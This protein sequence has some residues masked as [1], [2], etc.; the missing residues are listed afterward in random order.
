MGAKK[1]KTYKTTIECVGNNYTDVTGSSTLVDYRGKRVLVDFGFVQESNKLKQYKANRN[2]MKFGAKS[3]DSVIITHVGHLDH[4]G[5]LPTLFANGFDGNVITP[6]NSKEYLRIAFKDNI[7]IME[8]DLEY[9]NKHY[10][11]KFKPLYTQY[12]VDK[13]LESIIEVDFDKKFGINEYMYVRFLPNFHIYNSASVEL[14]IRDNHKNY[15]KKLAF[16]GD[17]GNITIKD[18]PFLNG[19]K[20]IKNCDLLVC[21]STYAMNNKQNGV[22]TRKKEIELIREL[23]SNTQKNKGRALFAVFANQRTEEILHVLYSMKDIINIPVV[24]DSPLAVKIMK[25]YQSTMTGVNKE[26][27]DEIMNWDNLKLIE[28]WKDSNAFMRSGESAIILSCSGFLQAGRVLDYLKYELPNPNSTVVFTGYGGG[29]GS[30]SHKILTAKKVDIG[31]GVQKVTCKI[32]CDKLQLKSF[33]SHMGHSKML[34][35]Y[36]NINVTNSVLICHGEKERQ[37]PFG[38]LLGEKIYKKGRN[39]KVIVPHRGQKIVI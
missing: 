21:E 18:K 27:I 30:L 35:Y 2:S 16:T 12:D 20:P 28:D 7:K 9:L 39:T 4:V 17:V 22:K 19:F 25:Y 36:S 38:L 32:L 26:D 6:P 3:I 37:Y 8:K 29:E 10:A 34:E 15:R 11:K 13:M 31:E 1:N 23:V 24:V 5:N 33:S 14:Y